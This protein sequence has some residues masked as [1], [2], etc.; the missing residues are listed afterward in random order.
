MVDDFD[1]DAAR[2]WFIEGAGGVAIKGGPGF[3]VDFGLQRSLQ[4]TIGIIGS[5]KIGVANEE[6]LFVVIGVDKPARDTFSAVTDDFAGLRFEDVHTVDFHSHPAVIFFQNVNVRFSKD[7]KEVAFAGVLQV[8]GHVEVGI[9]TGF[10]HRDATKL[11]E[12]GGMGLVVKGAGDQ[13]VKV[14]IACFARSGHKVG[15]LHGPKLWSN[16]DR[17]ALLGP[18]FQVPGFGTDKITRPGCQ[19]GKGDLVLFMRLLN[20]G[21]LEVL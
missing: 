4:G 17:G 13:Y 10:E 7:D 21:G 2:F 12:L 16:E 14:G 5:E 3:R 11:A 8:I 9:H 1:G 15:T 6:A 18:A 19:G 20:P